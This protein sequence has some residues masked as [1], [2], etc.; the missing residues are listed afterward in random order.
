MPV[1]KDIRIR[2]ILLRNNPFYY[3]YFSAPGKAGLIFLAVGYGGC[4]S[5][6]TCYPLLLCYKPA[7]QGHQRG[8]RFY[9]EAHQLREYASAIIN[10]NQESF[11]TI[12]YYD[13]C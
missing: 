4:R 11:S 10:E 2:N 7:P 12:F 6:R 1:W 5:D 13:T 8:I 3:Y 9:R